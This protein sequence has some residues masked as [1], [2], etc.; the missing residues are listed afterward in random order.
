[1]ERAAWTDERLDDLAEA[2]RSGFARIDQDLRDIRA[3]I[4]GVRSELKDQIGEHRAESRSEVG[5]LRAELSSEIQELRQ[6][7]LRVGAGL[8]GSMA[9]GFLSVF[10]AILVRGG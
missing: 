7:M 3:E 5:G 9:V 2:M 10:A 4:G 1:M 6:T 8:I